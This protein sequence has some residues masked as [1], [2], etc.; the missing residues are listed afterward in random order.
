MSYGKNRDSFATSLDHVHGRLMHLWDKDG[1]DWGA[2]KR[3]VKLRRCYVSAP[4][5]CQTAIS[6]GVKKPR[7][8]H[9]C[10]HL[11]VSD[12]SFISW[13]YPVYMVR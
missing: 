1:L 6:S 12:F 13:V 11:D 3:C 4:L 7:S 9:L 2:I 10:L 8:Q 5:P